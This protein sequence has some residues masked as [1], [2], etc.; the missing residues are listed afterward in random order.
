VFKLKLAVDGS[1][2]RYKA[3]LC[4]KGFTQR[5]G[6]DYTETF[7]PVAKFDSIR[8]ILSIAVVEDLHIVEFDVRT[9]FLYG[10]LD[11]VIYMEQPVGFRDSRSP[12]LVCRLHK[13][14]YGLKQSPR[15]WNRKFDNFLQN[16][17]L[18][19]FDATV[20]STSMRLIERCLSPFG[21]IMALHAPEHLL[22]ASSKPWSICKEPLKSPKDLLKFM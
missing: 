19:V 6:V 12:H 7:S 1:V 11:E 17:E 3:R 16:Y 10:E 15:V 14:L 21:L 22:S 13:A 18:L 5:E 4:A 8:A 2:H 20:A 9:A